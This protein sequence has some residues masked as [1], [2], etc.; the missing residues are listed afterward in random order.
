MLSYQDSLLTRKITNLSQ[1]LV[2][3][4]AHQR[5]LT[6]QA[7]GLKSNKI[8]IQSSLIDTGVYKY[9]TISSEFVITGSLPSKAILSDLLF[10]LYDSSGNPI[11]YAAGMWGEQEPVVLGEIDDWAGSAKNEWHTLI[12]LYTPG[13]QVDPPDAFYGDFWVV[14]NDQSSIKAIPR[15]YQ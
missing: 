2:S 5:Y 4:K 13:V 10:Q 1:E 15:Q 3:L 7:T 11:N 12:Y 8:R 6:G 9:R 14:A